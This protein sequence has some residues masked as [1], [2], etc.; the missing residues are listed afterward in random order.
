MCADAELR[1][2]VTGDF[3]MSMNV[4]LPEFFLLAA[5]ILAGWILIRRWRSRERK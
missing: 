1:Q 5:V 3:V 4:D 2:P